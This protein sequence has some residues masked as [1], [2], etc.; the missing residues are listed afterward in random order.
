MN[1]WLVGCSVKWDGGSAC[2]GGAV[3]EYQV[4]HS[5]KS[6]G[7]DLFLDVLSVEEVEVGGGDPSNYSVHLVFCVLIFV[8]LACHPYTYTVSWVPYTL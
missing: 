3:R 2:K 7:A 4:V 5:R 1:E 6:I 8:P